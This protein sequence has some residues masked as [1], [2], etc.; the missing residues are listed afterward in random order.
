MTL[1]I[2]RL[3]TLVQREL[4]SRSEFF[5]AMIEAVGN[6]PAGEKQTVFDSLLGHSSELV[7]E[8]GLRI[9]AW[10]RNQDL[11]RDFEHVRRHSP[12]QPGVRLE[13]F[14]G[15]AYAPE[16]RRPWLSGREY[17]SATFLRFER[18]GK[19]LTPVALVELDEAIDLPE[20]QG[21]YGV[22]FAR[23]GLDHPAWALAEGSVALCV[24]AALPND[25]DGFC[26]AH[27]FTE[28]HACYRVKEGVEEAEGAKG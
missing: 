21:R 9:Q 16:D 20:H 19:G 18:L 23:Y 25:M 3:V 27:P 7:R 2:D 4:I 8:E 13:L 15:D 12:L 10:L 24:V 6:L 28:R 26:D 11:S 22:L 17:A 14:A 5:Y 1:G